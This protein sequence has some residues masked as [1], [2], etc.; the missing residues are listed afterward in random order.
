M[1]EDSC[2]F[3]LL[4]GVHTWCSIEG[5][6][7]EH[8]KEGVESPGSVHYRTVSQRLFVVAERRPPLGKGARTSTQLAHR[9][10]RKGPDRSSE[11]PF[12]SSH[13]LTTSNH[14]WWWGL[15][16]SLRRDDTTITNWRWNGGRGG[17]RRRGRGKK[18]FFSAVF[19]SFVRVF[20]CGTGVRLIRASILAPPLLHLPTSPATEN[21]CDCAAPIQFVVVIE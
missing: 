14:S 7:K 3:P 17:R 9:Q 15:G 5:F 8:I 6:S 16:P 21:A 10:L 12:Y 18:V 11:A 20:R 1:R 2:L 13:P 4:V 19:C